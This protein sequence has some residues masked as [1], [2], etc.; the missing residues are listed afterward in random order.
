MGTVTR[1]EHDEAERKLADVPGWGITQGALHREVEFRNFVEAFGF[2]AMVA[3]AAEKLNHHPDWSNSWNRVVIDITNHAE[4]GISDT[5]FELAAA[6]N[7][8]LGE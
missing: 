4:G 8:A 5:C 3:L 2:M 7:T 1:L 6:V